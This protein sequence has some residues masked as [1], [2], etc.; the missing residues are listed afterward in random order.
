MTEKIFEAVRLTGVRALLSKGWGDL[1]GSNSSVP[2]NIFVLGDCP[3]AW[4]F[5]RVACVIHHG[6]AGTTAAGVAAGKPTVIVPF[7]G[8]QPFWGNMIARA[9]AGPRPIPYKILTATNLAAAISVALQPAM[10]E[11]AKLL[12][13]KI[14]GERGSEVGMKIF[15]DRLPLTVMG[16]SIVPHRVAVWKVRKT[17]IKLSAVAATLLRKEGLL[18][19]RTLKLY[20]RHPFSSRFWFLVR[21]YSH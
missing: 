19:F 12:G 5:E 13:A 10:L 17:N 15:H 3:H 11:N 21:K 20:A 2:P 18:D 1:G 7:F 9:G 6:G 14:R 4:L 8:D 16:C